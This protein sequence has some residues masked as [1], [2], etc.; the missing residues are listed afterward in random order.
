MDFRET[1][2]N[3]IQNVLHELNF[4]KTLVAEH[5]DTA[6]DDVEIRAAAFSHSDTSSDRHIW[7]LNR[8]ERSRLMR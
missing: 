4:V 5:A 3:E 1:V 6:L 2:R 8:S 7:I